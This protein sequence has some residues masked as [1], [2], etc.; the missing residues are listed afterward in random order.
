MSEREGER[1]REKEK[2]REERNDTRSTRRLAIQLINERTDKLICRGRVAPKK[3]NS[4]NKPYYIR[5][6][7]DKL[8]RSIIEVGIYIKKI[9]K[10]SFLPW[11]R[12]YFLFFL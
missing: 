5:R 10:C 11:S 3:I 8:R 12:L 1:K 4:Q 7:I 6:F 9:I 2:E